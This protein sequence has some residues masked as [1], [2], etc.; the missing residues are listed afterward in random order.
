MWIFTRDGFFSAVKDQYCGENELM[1][2]ARVR[3][4][5]ERFCDREALDPNDIMEFP[6]ADYRFRIKVP[7]GRWIAYVGTMAHDI[8]YPNFKGTVISRDHDRHTAYME[9]WRALHDWQVVA[10]RRTEGKGQ[11]KKSR[12][13]DTS[14]G[15][16]IDF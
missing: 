13:K 16:W 11:G 4:D 6:Q 10:Q 1:V 8:D 14:D 12:Y 2:R 7:R 3:D 9:C 5:L 15:D